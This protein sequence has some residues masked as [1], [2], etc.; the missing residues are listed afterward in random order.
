MRQS[1]ECGSKWRGDQ[2]YCG[3]DSLFTIIGLN[4]TYILLNSIRISLL[5]VRYLTALSYNF[6]LTGQ[7]GTVQQYD[8]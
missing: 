4:T 1:V 7:S 3:N 2:Q 5:I 6:K 8:N